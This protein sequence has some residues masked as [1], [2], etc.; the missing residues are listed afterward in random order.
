MTMSIT[1]LNK[2]N[3]LSI[4]PAFAKNVTYC[5]AVGIRCPHPDSDPLAHLI[6]VPLCQ[7]VRPVQERLAQHGAHSGIVKMPAASRNHK[8]TKSTVDAVQVG[9]SFPIVNVSEE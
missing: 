2:K 9:H 8:L 4:A 3:S 1:C 5:T 6:K 7:L